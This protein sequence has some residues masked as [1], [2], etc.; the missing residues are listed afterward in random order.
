MARQTRPCI[1]INADL[2]PASKLSGASLRLPLGYI[3]AVTEY[4]RKRES[5]P[6]MI[7]P[8]LGLIA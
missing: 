6:P 1:G 3:D 4:S 5:G 7:Q 2:L 8:K